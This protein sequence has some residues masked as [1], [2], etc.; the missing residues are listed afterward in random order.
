MEKQIIETTTL[1]VNEQLGP[2][3]WLATFKAPR[4][5]KIAQPGQFM[6]IE[7]S[8]QFFLKR[9]FSF[10]DIN[11]KA[12]TI[13]VYYQNKGLGTW[14]MANKWLI[15][16]AVQIQGPHGQGFQITK[17]TDDLLIVAG[18]IGIAP[19][20]ALIDDLITKKV[21]YTAI[22]G[23]R[24]KNALNV[25]SLFQDNTRFLL[26]T[27]DGTIGQQQNIIVALEQYLETHQPQMIV[28]CGPEVALTKI[29]QIAKEN[30]ITT[31]I[32]YESHMA[33]GVGACMGCTKTID[34]TN[35]KICTDGPIIT[36]KYDK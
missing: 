31:Q 14:F 15:G 4:L 12:E 20:K 2:D 25:L 23:G 36:V 34:G 26:N 33:C 29:N 3:L 10:F 28:A 17:E 19:M 35:K 5:S 13:A 24:T 27:D 6:L 32:S 7:P 9:P 22:F 18:G 8:Q 21:K 11:A 1:L 30:R 16:Q